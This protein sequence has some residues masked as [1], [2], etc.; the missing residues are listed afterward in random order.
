M[1]AALGAGG[2]AGAADDDFDQF[3]KP[4]AERS[5]RRRAADEDWD[6]ELE[7]DLLGEDLLSGKKNQS[8]L[9]DE[10]LN[11][12]LLQ[13]DNEDENFS[14]QGVTIS[15]KTTSG[16]VT[17]YELTDS[18]NDQSGEQESEYEQGE[19]ELVYHKSEGS[20][21]Y[22]HEYP[23]EGQYEG[24]EAELTGDH[25]EY[26]G[27]PEE[28]QL[29]SDEVLDIEINEPLDE[30][31][32]NMETLELQ[33]E[34]KE[35][36]DEEDDEDE[37]SGRLRFK[38]ER[39][40]GTIIRLSD[41][42]RERRNIPETLELSAEAKAALLEFEERERQHKQGRYGSR[43][44]GR[45]GGPLMCRGMGDQRRENSERGRMKD[46]RPALLPT[47][48]PVV[49]HSPRLIPQA[50]PQP[51]PPPPPQ[52]QPIRSLFQQQPLQ[53]LLP[54]QHPHHP[55]PPQG[56]HVPP[57]ME[58]PRVM[59]TPPPVTPQQPKNIHINP[60]FKGAVVTPVQVPLLPVPSQPRPAVGPQRFPGPP[61]F[62]QHTPGP[63]PNNF[64]QPPRLPLQDQWRAPPPPQE[65]DPFFLGVSG[66]PRFP[67]HLFLEQR[68]PPPP[69]PPPTLLSSS[70]PVPTPS[71]LPF[72]QPGPAFNQQGQ[73]P[74]FP[75][76][77]PVRP[78]LQP[79]GPVGLLHFSQP[80]SAAARPFIPPRQ[81]FLPGPGQPFLPTH[82]QPTLQGPLHPPL[83]PPHQPPPQPQ[84]QPPLQPPPQHPP[85]PQP[86]H[87]PPH[88]PQ[89]HQHHHHLSVPPP[90]LMPMSQPQFRPHMQT[91]Q[92][93]QN[94]SRMQCPQRQGLRHNT[95]SQSA[96]KRP[97]QQLQPAAPRNSNLRELPIAPS[98]VL[99]L[100]H[101]R[102]A[103]TPG[104][105]GK[106]TGST[107]PPS[108]PGPGPRSAQGKT[109]MK[110]KP[111]SPEG[112]PKEEAKAEPEV[113][114]E[115]EETRLYRLKIE[116]QKRLREE[117]L[118]QKELRRQQQAGARKKELLERLAQQQ[119]LC[120][121]SAPVEREEQP[122][123]PSPA[124]GNPLLP[125]PGAQVRP[126]VKNRLLVKNQDVTLSSLQPKTSNFVPSGA[127][128]PYPGQPAKPLKHLRHK[129]LQAQPVDG[130]AQPPAQTARVTAFQGRPPDVKPGAKR[131]VMHRAN[132]GGGDGPH[133]GSKVRVIKLSGGQGGESDGFFHP[134]GQ[135]Q[136]PP[137]PPEVRQQPARKV[138]LTKGA[139]QQPQHLP[140][141]AHVYSAGPPG[142][143]SIQGIHPAKKV[144]M[145]GRGRG[146][147][148]PMG[149]GRPTPNKQNLRVV[150]CK[151]QPCAVSVEGLSSSTTDVQ[152]KSL[153]MS[154]GPIQSLQMLPQQRKA[155]AK[156]KEPAH[157][158]AFQQKF[159]RHMIDLSHINVALIVE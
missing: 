95:T 130:D 117:I 12:D 112:Q 14:S 153:L 92:P 53:P 104:A 118:K 8:D 48:P 84:Q 144:L 18:T 155:I 148:G 96:T 147:A 32:G 115:D 36:S 1:A 111:V 21:L 29:Y 89:Q 20:E 38:T 4:G 141:G 11:D 72:A 59:M 122:A 103:S 81:P 61:E 34:M 82:A 78:A 2:G 57:Q 44:G 39:K 46:H 23:A 110:A 136:R 88:Q 145:H 80:G 131:T 5:W 154:V 60:H 27:E 77:R 102:G 157:A 63:V 142:I 121:P 43:R 54:L 135:S 17:S 139:L 137:Q 133:V 132:S 159:H 113:P 158:L 45:R 127:S 97:T 35:E 116:E 106:P 101:S 76:E 87:Q 26:V 10:E 67:S 64:S 3:D 33:K 79:P 107:S 138:T 31:T 93:Q 100:S 125:F 73:Q 47:Q 37:E 129:V 124:N 126:N 70:H 152:L 7:D 120:A 151:P 156:F 119:Q 98:H 40:E 71:P 146:A 128:M 85:P 51:P 91:A 56:M 114:E 83:P 143:K 123:P 75:R 30:F 105:H 65:R 108:R 9:S 25:M 24:Q 49:T 86:Q 58:A 68:S 52:Q 99:E 134:D 28:G 42:T 74:V 16:M 13:S 109:D 149:R 50:Q 69:P 140:L 41:V 150:E 66:E 90:P 19:D 62:P 94:S 6:S 22:A 15:L 55:S